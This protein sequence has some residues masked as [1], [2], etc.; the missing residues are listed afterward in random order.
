METLKTCAADPV[1]RGHLDRIIDH[2]DVELLWEHVWTRLAELGHEDVGE[3][4][5][6]EI[7]QAHQ[8]TRD[9]RE[10]TWDRAASVIWRER[11]EE[12]PSMAAIASTYLLAMVRTN[13][14]HHIDDSPDQ[15]IWQVDTS[16][17]MI[18]SMMECHKMMRE[19]AEQQE[20]DNQAIDGWA[21]CWN[22]V[23]VLNPS[24]MGDE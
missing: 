23:G 10:R 17:A 20:S 13:G 5:D 1:I 22:V 16:D 3:A 6:V 2:G 24:A 19:E 14:V 9:R 21:T 7:L 8:P 15:I 4:A 11:Q 12:L 18:A